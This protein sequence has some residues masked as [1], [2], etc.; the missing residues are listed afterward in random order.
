MERECEE[1]QISQVGAPNWY[2]AGKEG[3][4]KVGALEQGILRRS[5]EHEPTVVL[6]IVP[7]ISACVQSPEA[8]S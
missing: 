6:D 7:E 1:A 4:Q 3:F 8:H 2:G 5:L